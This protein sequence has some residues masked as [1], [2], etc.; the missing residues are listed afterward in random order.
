MHSVNHHFAKIHCQGKLV[1][2]LRRLGRRDSGKQHACDGGRSPMV[3]FGVWPVRLG[4]QNPANQTGTIQERMRGLT[5]IARQD[6]LGGSRTSGRDLGLSDA[7]GARFQIIGQGK[8]IF[9]RFEM[10]YGKG[11]TGIDPDA[12]GRFNGIR[13]SRPARRGRRPGFPCRDRAT[14]SGRPGWP[15]RR[16]R[17]G[18]Q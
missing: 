16:F 4:C 10:G 17:R 18:H 11:A 7:R 2:N 12:T 3:V 6:A 8:L 1:E 14:R 15:P 5:S 9:C 13:R